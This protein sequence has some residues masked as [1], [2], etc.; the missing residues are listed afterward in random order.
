M[1][2]PGRIAELENKFGENPRRYFAALANEYRKLGDVERAIELCERHLAEQ[3]NHLSGHVV[4]AQALV[5]ARRD[6]AAWEPLHTALD[7]DPENF[8]ALRL[9]GDLSARAGDAGQAR[10]YY[11][12][13]LEIE[14]RSEQIIDALKSL[15]QRREEPAAT[16][17][18]PQQV[19]EQPPEEATDVRPS[20]PLEELSPWGDE[21]QEQ[22]SAATADEGAPTEVY[23]SAESVHLEASAEAEP[24]A[25]VEA[26][27]EPGEPAT[28]LPLVPEWDFSAWESDAPVESAAATPESDEEIDSAAVVHPPQD[29]AV[30]EPSIDA[31]WGDVMQQDESVSEVIA[32]DQTPS[33][34]TLVSE[35]M[36]ELYLQQGHIALALQALR[37]LV[38]ARPEDERLRARLD[39]VEAQAAPPPRETVRDLFARLG[40]GR[41]KGG[42]AAHALVEAFSAPATQPAEGP[43][44]GFFAEEG[45]AP[46]DLREDEG[47][48]AA[49]TA[50][51]DAP[52][53]AATFER[54]LQDL[55]T[56]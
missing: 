37:E 31:L 33:R 42:E 28:D 26:A 39:E 41:Q 11:F 38:E 5:D 51:G 4:L 17:E 10:A 24:Q 20:W 36:V 2:T 21:L 6:D 1:D 12:R 47:L 14:P 29:D 43:L 54:W 35:T 25:A 7:L 34:P 55:R 8:I 56:Q 44:T 19:I 27:P 16:P 13:A 32:S 40:R 46:A 22:T 9:L 15:S 53:D 3:H 48:A 45:A 30:Q 23:A 18:P 52:A 50:P 49:L